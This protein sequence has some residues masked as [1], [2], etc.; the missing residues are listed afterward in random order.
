MLFYL[1]DDQTVFKGL[2][3]SVNQTMTLNSHFLGQMWEKEEYIF[4]VSFLHHLM[5]ILE[6]VLHRRSKYLHT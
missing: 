5:L 4:S 6:C 3:S 2:S 1:Y